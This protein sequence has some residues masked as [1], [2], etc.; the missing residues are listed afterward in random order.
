MRRALVFI[1]VLAFAATAL[2]PAFAATTAKKPVSAICPVLGTKIPDISKAPAKS[3]YK[4]K[5]YYF[6][7]KIC[8]SKFDKDPGKYIKKP[9]SAVCPVMGTKIPDI[10]K[11]AGKSVYKGKTYYFCC[12]S[13]K[14]KF[15]KNPEKYIEKASAEQRRQKMEALWKKG[16][17]LALSKSFREAAKCYEQSLS[18]AKELGDRAF[19]AEKLKSAAANYSD[20]G[21]QEKAE[22][23]YQKAL[24]VYRELGD[25]MGQGKCLISLGNQRFFRGEVEGKE[26]Y[27]QALPLLE[28]AKSHDWEAYCR[29]MLDLLAEVGDD[30]FPNLPG[31]GAACDSLEKKEGV[32]KLAGQP[33]IGK[34]FFDPDVPELSVTSPIYQVA[35]LGK[36]LDDSVPV[37]GSWSGNALPYS[38][39]PLRATVTV[40]SD[41]ESVKV[42]AGS[43]E[44]CLLTEQVTTEGDAPDDGVESGKQL[45]QRVLCGTRKAWYAPGVGLV[46]LHVRTGD[47]TEAIIQLTKFTVQG[48]GNDYLPLAVGNS[49]T[50]GW[51]YLPPEWTAKE[52][53][54]VIANEGDMWYLEHYGYSY[55]Q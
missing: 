32:V 39:Q 22:E 3:V 1:A 27:K 25:S 41:S 42:P 54:R 43:F 12:P 46:K 13:C 47:G 19:Q 21:Q 52:V 37:G 4:G 6:C 10:S 38:H 48:A 11:A 40:K 29:A 33:G 31:Y 51:A 50:Y 24:Q 49:W 8:K 45:N 7:C 23:C 35:Q 36:F 26:T 18:I 9:V 2:A 55:Q 14:P 17:A 16:E 34:G 5:T 15:D 53:Y 44:H 30:R 20:M 28:A